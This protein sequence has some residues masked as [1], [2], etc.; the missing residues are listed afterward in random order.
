VRQYAK[1]KDFGVVKLLEPGATLSLK[2]FIAGTTCRRYIP[3]AITV[4]SQSPQT[5]KLLKMRGSTN[6][7]K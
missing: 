3:A 7:N 2:G 6:K 1:A 5:P 4:D